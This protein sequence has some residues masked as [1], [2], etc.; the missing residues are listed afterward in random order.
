[1][2]AEV[3]LEAVSPGGS[4]QALVEQ[5]RRVAYLYVFDPEATEQ[6]VKSCWVR[7]LQPAPE[8]LDL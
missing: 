3:I 8:T 2:T 4:L 7:N 1:M 5:D 6:K